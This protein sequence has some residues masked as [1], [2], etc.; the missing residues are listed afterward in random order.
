MSWA[1]GLPKP[2][3]GVIFSQPCLAWPVKFDNLCIERC[4]ADGRAHDTARRQGMMSSSVCDG[5]GL[6]THAGKRQKSGA[7]VSSRT[8]AKAAERTVQ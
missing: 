5:G 7:V 2:M 6:K 4:K 1:C 3:E 8:K